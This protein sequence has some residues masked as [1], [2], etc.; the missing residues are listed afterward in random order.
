MRDQ[1]PI[2]QR[3]INGYPLVYLD[4]A[5]T[6]QKPNSVIDAMNDY[7][8]NSNANVHR[9]VH[10]LAGE[11]TEGYE[12][13]R[14]AL[15]SR[16]NANKAIITSGTTEAINLVAHAWGRANLS[17]GDAV[18][19]TEMEHHSDIVPWQM[20][21]Q[22]MNIELRYVPVQK[23]LTLDMDLFE[24][25]IDGAKLVCV[26]HI[27]NV[28][29][30][31]NPVADIVRIAKQN[32]ARVLLD[33]A[34]SAPHQD[35]DFIELGAD[36][37]AFSAHKMCGPTGI[38]AL[39]VTDDAFSEMQPFMGGGDMIETVSIRGS[40]Y[41]KNEQKFEA[42]TPRIAEA[43]GWTEAI[44]WLNDIDIKSEHQRILQSARWLAGQ[45]REMGMTVYGRHDD[46][47]AAVVSFLHPTMNSEDL[48]HLLDARGFAVR[49]GHHCAQPLLERLEITG[50]VRVSLYFYNTHEEVISFVNYLSEI[51][52]RFA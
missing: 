45:L 30:V 50:T 9:A 5:A 10:T 22:E 6:T 47:D 12:S 38:G 43:I 51:L 15:K 28:L 14:T 24:A 31:C 27:S 7:Y 44:K 3:E 33:A 26:V 1:F 41:Q 34:Q 19:L 36:F 52:E 16:F 13:C 42:G 4:N 37:M 39:L 40:T 35:I 29:G 46:N 32:G 18:I 11:A 20:L 25:A 2:L 49:T 8:S 21:A 48:A 23:D 17:D